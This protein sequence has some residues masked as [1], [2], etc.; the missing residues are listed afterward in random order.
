MPEPER[1]KASR[2]PLV[3]A[4]EIVELPRGT[5]FLARTSDVSRLGCYVDT[6]NP[7]SQTSPVRLR[8]THHQ[9]VFEALGHVIYVSPGLGMGITFD[10]VTPVQQARLE[11]WLDAPESEF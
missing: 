2:F 10:T 6:L 3:L 5:K 9:E 11:H 8:L 1:R 4:A 7:I